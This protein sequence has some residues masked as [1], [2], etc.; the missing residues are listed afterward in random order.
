MEALAH[1]YRDDGGKP[2]SRPEAEKAKRPKYLNPS[3]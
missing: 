3:T 1:D 2:M